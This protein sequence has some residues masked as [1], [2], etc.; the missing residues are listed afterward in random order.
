ME[1]HDVKVIM[2]VKKAAVAGRNLGRFKMDLN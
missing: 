1:L 2:K